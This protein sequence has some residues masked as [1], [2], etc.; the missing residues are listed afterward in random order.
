MINGDINVGDVV[1]AKAF[2]GF[3]DGTTKGS[4]YKVTRVERAYKQRLFFI[5]NDEG[6]EVLPVSTVF[7]KEANE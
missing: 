5:I 1:K 7:V 6:K 2:C 4:R 3:P